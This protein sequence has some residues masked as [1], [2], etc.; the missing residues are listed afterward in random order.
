MTITKDKKI[1]DT[2]ATKAETSQRP[3]KQEKKRKKPRRRTDEEIA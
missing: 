2:N 1:K 3:R